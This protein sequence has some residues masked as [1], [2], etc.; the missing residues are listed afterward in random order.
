MNKN[1]TIIKSIQQLY[2]N[3]IMKINIG[4][5]VSKKFVVAKGLNQGCCL[6]TTLFK[7][8]MKCALK[9][10]EKIAHVRG[11]VNDKNIYT[12]GR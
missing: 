7:I 3:F 12:D 9:L 4:N 8:Y 11:R 1:N 2:K 10:G 6:S 5:H